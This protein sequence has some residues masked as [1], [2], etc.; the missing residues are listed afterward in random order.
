M[1]LQDRAFSLS[2]FRENANEI[3]AQINQT[4]EPGA[5][6]VDGEVRAVLMSASDYHELLRRAQLEEDAAA[7]RRAM[8][9]FDEGKGEPAEIGFG[10]LRDKLLAM[11]AAQDEGRLV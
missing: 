9:E 3:L 6:I 11:K 8:R 7:I 1:K 5:I 10:R 4:N 2:E